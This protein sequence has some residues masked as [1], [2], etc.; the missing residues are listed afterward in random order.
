MTAV[1]FDPPVD[2]STRVMYEAAAAGLNA[3]GYSRGL[4]A[5]QWRPYH[6]FAPP[7]RRSRI[8]GRPDVA[9]GDG[10]GVAAAQQWAHVLGLVELDRDQAFDQLQEHVDEG[11]RL[12]H[13]V[14]SGIRVILQAQTIEQH[15]MQS[16]PAARAWFD[17]QVRDTRLL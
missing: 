9:G 2:E 1:Q 10:A 15:I 4:P 17:A 3:A 11:V 5:M 8:Y 12:W 13:G 6:D 16:N 7:S 14:V